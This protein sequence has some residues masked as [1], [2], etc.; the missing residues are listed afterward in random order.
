MLD[1]HCIDPRL[2]ELYDIECGW[3]ED[4]D[5]YLDLAGPKPIDILDIGCGTGLL[6]N[7][8]AARGHRVTG[9]DPAAAMLDVAR[10]SKHGSRVEWIEATAQTLATR[11]RFDLI[12]MTG[13]AF[14]TLLEERD[15]AASFS[16]LGNALKPHGRFVFET[17]N[18]AIDWV[19]KWTHELT[20]DTPWGEVAVSRRVGSW[21]GE[22]ID[23]T[24]TYRF[25]D[26]EL[27]S[28]SELRFWTE[29]DIRRSATSAGLVVES[30]LGDWQ[31]EAFDPS[32]SEEMIFTLAL[33]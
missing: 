6:A 11:R 2:V 7:A 9:V 10:R 19:G 17:R 18:P 25:A 28:Q 23:F 5:F 30:L 8:Y 20:L 15:I 32:V 14:Q 27:A 3:S 1:A 24:T 21:S 33:P 16:N 4:R 13:H 31:C 22:R 12:I 29:A 26:G